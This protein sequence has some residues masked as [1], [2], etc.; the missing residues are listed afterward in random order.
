MAAVDEKKLEAIVAQQIELAKSHDSRERETDRA[1]ALDYYLGKMDK[2]IPPEVNR[3]KVV[4]RDV[5]D[6]IGWMLPGIIRVFSASDR[7][8]VAEPVGEEDVQFARQA[9]DGMNYVFWKDNKGYE[10]IYSVTWDA[11]LAGNGVVKTFYDDTPV[12]TTSF[13]SGLDENQRA[14]LLFQVDKQTGEIS[15]DEAGEPVANPDVEVLAQTPEEPT[16]GEPLPPETL[17]DLKIKRKKA[18]GKFVIE[19]IPPESFLIDEDAKTTDE[20]AF[21][22]HWER[23]MRSDLIAMG[24][25]KDTVFEIPAAGKNETPEESARREAAQSSDAAD[26]ST[27]LVDYYECFIRIDVDDDGEAELVRVC[28]GGGKTGKLLHWEVWEDENP[29]DDIPCEPVPHRWTARSV[30]DE[31]MDVQDI[32]TTL[33]RQG[34]NNLY[35]TNSPQRHVAGK[36]DNPDELVNPTFGGV[37]FTPAGTIITDL[38]VPFVANHV[39]EAMA[40]QDEVIQRRTG[41]SRQGMALDPETLQNQTATASQQQQDASYSQVEQ[42]A[43]N[44]AEWGWSKVFRKLLKLLIKHQGPRSLMMNG[45]SV[46]IDPRFWNADMDVTINVGLGTGSRDRDLM[47]L[48]GV[49]QTQL[50]LADRFMATGAVQ[51]AID[52]LPKIIRTMTKMAESA[53]IRNPEDYYP[54]Y[55]QEKID[56]LKQMASQPKPDPAVEL[57]KVK[58]QTAKEIKAFEVQAQSQTEQMQM[59]REIEKERAQMQA[60]LEVKMA[61]MQAAERGEAQKQAFEAAKFDAEQQLDRERMAEEARQK[62]LDR[63]QQFLI[64]QMKIDAQ[65]AAAAESNALAREQGQQNNAVKMATAKQPAKTEK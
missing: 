35:A 17:Y 19:A 7:M 47:H 56:Q 61:E 41:V 64:E 46:Q 55:T 1:K 25:D 15:M 57:E 28:Q 54:E 4:S 62:D 24:Y 65:R 59:Q 8:A 40:Q 58:A 9:T 29:F 14:M 31:T 60:D 32:K 21:T 23:K 49:L 38:V 33:A 2:Y 51:D 44:M 42:I 3:S 53:G 16:N 36:V 11:L 6:T 52:M 12:Y 37:V 30:S 43:R 34:L 18:D 45:K 39:F 48:Q 26:K 63:R 5:A 10:I 13:H 22:A 20:A 27:E 50:G